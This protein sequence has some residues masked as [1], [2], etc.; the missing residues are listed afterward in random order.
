MYELM[1]EYEFEWEETPELRI[2]RGAGAGNKAG[3]EVSVEKFK[4]P[5]DVLRLLQSVLHHNSV[6]TA[7]GLQMGTSTRAVCGSQC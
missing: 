2:V 4:T 6:S 3:P 7:G 1:A 5:R